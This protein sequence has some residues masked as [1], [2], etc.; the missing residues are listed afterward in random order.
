[1][2]DIGAVLP[3]PK[4]NTGMEKGPVPLKSGQRIQLVPMGRER[5]LEAYIY[6]NGRNGHCVGKMSNIPVDLNLEDGSAKAWVEQEAAKHNLK[7][8]PAWNNQ[9]AFDL[10]WEY[11]KC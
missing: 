1:M 4:S 2:K 11:D 6:E 9:H 7:I 10:K 5:K 3:T 8:V